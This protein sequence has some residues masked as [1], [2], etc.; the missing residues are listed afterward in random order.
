MFLFWGRYLR[1]HEQIGTAFHVV[2]FVA[3]PVAAVCLYR[4]AVATLHGTERKPFTW[5]TILTSRRGYLTIGLAVSA[6]VLFGLVSRGATGS[7]SADLDG[8][9]VSQKKSTW[10][11]K[12]D[13][14]SDSVIGAQLHRANLRQASAI[15]AFFAGADLSAAD[16]ARANL[17]SANLARADLSFA[18]LIGAKLDLA[19]LRL[20]DLIGARLEGAALRAADL[21]GADLDGAD[22]NSAELGYADM[23]YGADLTY[24]DFRH[25]KNLK[26]EQVKLAEHWDK[27]FYDCEIIE[28]LRLPLD[29]NV[30]LFE[31]LHKDKEHQSKQGAKPPEPCP[32][33]KQ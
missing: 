13:Q 31:E 15:G 6:G 33:P 4:L 11:G 9:E 23:T 12:E 28:A 3:S 24:S 17:M 7:I 2:L 29:N 10:G 18:Y 26:P 22:L 21:S 25:T 19:D 1:R 30:K 14:N 27:A 16:L 20:A 8:A 5:K 32:S